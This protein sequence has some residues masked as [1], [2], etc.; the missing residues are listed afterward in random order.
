MTSRFGPFIS[1]IAT[2]ETILHNLSNE[3]FLYRIAENKWNIAE[4]VAH[5]VD[6]EIQAYTRFRSILADDVPYLSN[7]NE[8]KW[9]VTI[10]LL[11][12]SKANSLRHW[13]SI[14]PEAG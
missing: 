4:I 3:Q 1:E 7:H 5:L 10:G 14:Q 8:A 2:L 13:D 12:P 11:N 6:T 9:T